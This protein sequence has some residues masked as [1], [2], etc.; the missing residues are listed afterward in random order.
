[1]SNTTTT[2]TSN[3]NNSGNGGESVNNDL[4]PLPLEVI[5]QCRGKKIRIIMKGDKEMEGTLKGFDAYVNVILE[6]V[7][8]LETTP[9]GIKTTH[10]DE[11]LL[12]GNNICI[13][14]PEQEAPE[15]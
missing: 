8:E 13:M 1:M 11:I 5:N 4:Y 3:G 15:H 2:T 9:D 7:T 6:N 10:R 14:V 12:N